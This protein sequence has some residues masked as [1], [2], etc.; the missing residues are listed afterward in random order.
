MLFTLMSHRNLLDPVTVWRSW[1]KRVDVLVQRETTVY[2]VRS[3]YLCLTKV[4]FVSKT[5]W[6]ICWK[7]KLRYLWKV[8]FTV[9]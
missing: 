4:E 3:E 7:G 1:A 2:T 6:L 5:C 9:Q 8:F